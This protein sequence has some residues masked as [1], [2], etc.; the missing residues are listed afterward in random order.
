MPFYRFGSTDKFTNTVVTHPSVEFVFY[1]GSAYYNQGI[2]LSGAYAPSVG[3]IPAGHANLYEYNIDRPT[4]SS[5]I[6]ADLNPF[7][8]EGATAAES[9][10]NT[11]LIYPWTVKD[12]T[13][14]AFRTVT[15][16]A[17]NTFNPGE[18]ITGS[19]PMS[20]SITKE[21]YAAA[22]GRTASA[23]I[24]AAADLANFGTPG[25]DYIDPGVDNYLPPAETTGSTLDDNG[26][27]IVT[28][29]T[30]SHLFALRNTLE[31]YRYLSAHYIVSSSAIGGGRDLTA[32]AADTGVGSTAVPVGLV[33][34]PSIFYGSAI[35][36][37]S[38]KLQFYVTGALQGELRDTY[39]NGELIQSSGAISANDGQVAGVVLYNE[40]CIV[41]TGSW[42]LSSHEEVYASGESATAPAWIYFAQSIS[43]SLWSPAP[44]S[45]FAMCMS[46]TNKTQTLTMLANAKKGALNHS[47]NPTYTGYGSAE[48]TT[49][50]G[51]KPR[52]V[53]NNR[54]TI[55]NI[56]SSS[57]NDPTGSFK[58]TTYIS[59]IGIYDK[60]KNLIAIAKVA[61]PVRKTEERDFTFKLKLDI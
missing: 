8:F 41:L 30:V 28:Q 43:G 7:M 52:Y 34:I 14:T 1:S 31:N 9:V 19:Y 23:V 53:Q 12:G 27:L 37:G 58:K 48:I 5:F 49:V 4:G 15:A 33:S 46:G 26:N 6:D 59:K 57:Y 60:N 54:L 40:G 16:R 13:R 3:H 44:S 36:K 56:V 39:K 10:N 61:T 20:A 21:L 17:Y 50:N 38:V 51:E 32:S 45:S 11:G 18:I 25:A 47:N 35:K 29:A 24:G 2:T 42:A 55:K 22:T